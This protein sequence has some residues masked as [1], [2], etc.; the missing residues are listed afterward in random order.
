MHPAP[1]TLPRYVL[2]H[3]AR[4]VASCLAIAATVTLQ[5]L[6][7]FLVRYVIDGL[8]AGTLTR[9]ELGAALSLFLLGTGISVW[10]GLLMRRLPLRIGYDVER[11]LRDDLFAHLTTLDRGFF[12]THQTGDLMTRASSDLSNVREY[13]GQ[14]ILQGSRTTLVVAMAFSIMAFISL[15][16]TLIMLALLPSISV[17]CFFVL[18]LIRPRHDAVQQQL[19]DLTHFTQESF[20]GIR[21]L[22]GYAIEDRTSRRFAE[23]NAEF[24]RRNLALSLVERG[25]WPLFLFLFALGQVLLLVFGGRLVVQQRLTIGGLVQ[26]MQYMA[27]MQWPMLALGWAMNLLV[28]GRASWRRVQAL[29]QT[30]PAVHDGAVTQ[31]HLQDVRGDIEFRHVSLTLDGQALLRDIHLTLPEGATIGITG[32]TGSGKSL[33]AALLVRLV[34]PTEGQVFI[35]VHDIREYP[36]RVLR[37]HIGIATQEPFLFAESLESNILFG[38]DEP[39]PKTLEWAAEVAQLHGDVETFP[40][41]Y[42][43]MLGE[44]GVTLS[45]GQ[46]RRAAISRAVARNPEILILDD[47]LAAVDTQTEARI[48]ERLHGV[49]KERTAIVVSHRISSLRQA[50]LILV[51]ESG[52]IT[53]MGTHDDLLQREG[54]YKNLERIQRLEAALEKPA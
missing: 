16:L 5:V 17:L 3:K 14:G 1:P 51:L 6:L 32:P 26:F 2:R 23:L 9:D 37:G 30:A 39:D 41:R 50:D 27:Y 49:L 35:G 48:L 36:L 20:S 46:R 19:S 21:T 53:D 40:A 13:V 18:R 42:E 11:V 8:D 10:T 43:T 33:L 44:R 34:E 25:I 45:G 24:V 52:R 15:P 31:H 47:V 29:M 12:A 4:I 28:R 38:V 7:P 54:Y 22:K